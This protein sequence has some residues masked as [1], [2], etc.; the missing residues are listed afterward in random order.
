MLETL[1]VTEKI[2]V[3]TPVASCE[4]RVCDYNNNYYNE[5]ILFFMSQLGC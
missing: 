5:I 4:F 2:N 3:D 1:K